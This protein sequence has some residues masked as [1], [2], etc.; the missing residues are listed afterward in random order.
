M[1]QYTY[2][3]L[4]TKKRTTIKGVLALLDAILSIFLLD[5]ILSILS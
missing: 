5:A 1:H 3:K 2:F 4:I